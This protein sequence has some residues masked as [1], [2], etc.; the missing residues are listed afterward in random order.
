MTEDDI[1]YYGLQYQILLQ[2][3]LK[4]VINARLELN[5]AEQEAKSASH[6]SVLA[7]NRVDQCRTTLIKAI[8]TLDERIKLTP[9]DAVKQF[10]RES[11]FIPS[12][13]VE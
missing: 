13:T 4:V 10:K 12:D 2:E 3:T 5:A 11:G 1:N 8:S 6:A 9:S 7:N